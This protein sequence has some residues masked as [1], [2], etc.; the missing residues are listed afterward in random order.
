MNAV[1][2]YKYIK[3][4]GE[5]TDSSVVTILYFNI[6]RNTM[7]HGFI[8]KEEIKNIRIIFQTFYRATQ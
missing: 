1:R 2:R 8:C 4:N 6:N 5:M 3:K 7:L